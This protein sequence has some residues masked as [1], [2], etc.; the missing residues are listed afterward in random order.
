MRIHSAVGIVAALSSTV[1]TTFI[2]SRRVIVEDVTQ[3]IPDFSQINL[4]ELNAVLAGVDLLSGYVVRSKEI[5]GVE[6]F[7][8]STC[9]MG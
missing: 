5:T 1:G 4:H 2:L 8:D 3:I 7:V 6:L 9:V